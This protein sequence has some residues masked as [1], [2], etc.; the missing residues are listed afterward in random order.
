MTIDNERT[1]QTV[2]HTESTPEDHAMRS[3]EDHPS[4]RVVPKRG[5]KRR[6]SRGRYKRMLRSLNKLMRENVHRRANKDEHCHISKRAQHNRRVVADIAM[7]RLHE[8]GCPIEDV[9]H[10]KPRHEIMLK[11]DWLTR[12][13]NPLS[14]ATY[15]L[16]VS[17]MH[18]VAIWIK[19]PSLFKDSMKYVPDGVSIQRTFVADKERFLAGVGKADIATMLQEGTELDERFGCLLTLITCF[20]LRTE[21]ALLFHP[22]SALQN[23]VIELKYGTKGGRDRVLYEVLTERQ[24]TALKWAQRLVPNQYE[25]MIPSRYSYK[26]YH[27]RYRTLCRKF[28][29]TKKGRWGFTP[30]AL[31]QLKLTEIYVAVAGGLPPV[32]GGTAAD[33]SRE[34]DMAARKVIAHYAGHGRHEISKSYLGGIETKPKSAPVD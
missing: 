33:V 19:K 7:R 18:Q 2:T 20:A 15:H 32:A 10:L 1:Q 6:R 28:G 29:L 9:H 27:N 31:R 30:H 3:N 34:R 12:A 13:E 26:E 16:Y 25:S 22:H 21:E 17:V 4:R 14:P 5:S 11:N 8:L 23:G 24:T